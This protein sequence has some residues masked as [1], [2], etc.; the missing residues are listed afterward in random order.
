[1]KKD[2]FNGK[3]MQ[4]FV[5]YILTY[6]V[7]IT[8]LFVGLGV[9]II[10]CA[11]LESTSPILYERIFVGILGAI[12]LLLGLTYFVLALLVIRKYPKYTKLRRHLFN[13]DIYF[14]GS[15]SKEYFGLR[16]HKTSFNLIVMS[17]EKDK[18]AEKIKY[19]LR[20]KVCIILSISMFALFVASF[21]ALAIFHSN[22]ALLPDALQDDRILCIVFLCSI[23]FSLLSAI[24]FVLRA[25]KIKKQQL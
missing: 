10:Y 22:K 23:A 14:K 7:F 25:E 8:S 24:F 6:I 18:R 12:L 20:Y 13:S 19:P 1:M 4:E 17:C 3:I 11:T 9:F 5:S 21:F 2:I 15:N 16:R